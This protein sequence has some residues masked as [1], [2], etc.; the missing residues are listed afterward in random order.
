VNV[1]TGRNIVKSKT[2]DDIVSM[3]VKARGKKG[4]C[5]SYVKGIADKLHEMGIEDPVVRADSTEI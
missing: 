4:S 1:Y 2:I 5:V 3:I